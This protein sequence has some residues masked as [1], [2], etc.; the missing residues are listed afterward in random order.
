MREHRRFRFDLQVQ[1]E[2][3]SGFRW[4][5]AVFWA[6][7]GAVLVAGA[8]W[9]TL[10]SVAPLRRSNPRTTALIEARLQA[11][12]E[13]GRAARRNQHW[14]S[15]GRISPWLQRAVVNSEDARFFQHHGFDVVETGVA[16][17]KAVEKGR[18]SRGASTLTQQLAKNLWL[19]EERTLWRK[20][21]EYFIA[22]RLETLGKGRILELYLNVAEWGDGI[23]GAD[24]ASR[25]WFNKPASDL[26]PEEAA[27]LAAMLPAPRR[28]NP[29]HPSQ[30]LRQRAAE[31]LELYG[32]YR[33][34]TPEELAQ[35]RY[36]LGWILRS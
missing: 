17:E 19:G 12:R 15:L 29:A 31:V 34:L 30:K 9:L 2:R 36:R 18:F 32:V 7:L 22:R 28:R 24:A 5:R 4:G 1:D 3:R 21:R 25:F 14:V 35:A 20:T 6:A 33:E 26:L 16:L 8:F 13:K 27:V 11:A 23:Y 10:P